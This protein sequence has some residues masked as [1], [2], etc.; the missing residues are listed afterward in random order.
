LPYDGKGIE[1]LSDNPRSQGETYKYDPT[2]NSNS[3]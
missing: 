3:E 2:K 1:I